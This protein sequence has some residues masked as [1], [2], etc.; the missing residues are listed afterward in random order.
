VV[1]TWSSNNSTSGYGG[2][3][4]PAYTDWYYR[5]YMVDNFLRT[6]WYRYPYF[7]YWDLQWQ[8]SQNDTPLNRDV[9][10]LALQDS[11]EA[12]N[13]IMWNVNQMSA[14]TDRLESGQI[15]RSDFQARFDSLTEN[16]RRLT[17]AIRKDD[18]LEFL[19]QRR[20]VS[21]NEP[22][23]A[24]S[25][26]ELR[27]LVSQLRQATSDMREGFETYYSRDYTRTI[28]LEHLKQP[29]FKSMSN[30]IDKLAKVIGQSAD[31]L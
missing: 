20:G 27:Q 21:M 12:T 26:A 3:Y 11:Y 31:H 7:S 1:N 5:Q 18:R 24:R 30:Q 6:L 15:S 14:L 16:V 9:I 13:A 17:R 2:G 8:Y 19:D 23:K 28:D 29:S 4:I 25:I 22:P 10:R